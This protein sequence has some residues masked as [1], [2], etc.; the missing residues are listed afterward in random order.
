MKKR[1]AFT[2]VVAAAVL[3][4]L[5]AVAVR[6][7]AHLWAAVHPLTVVYSDAVF[8]PPESGQ[9]QSLSYRTFVVRSDG[10]A[11]RF[12]AAGSA[13]ELL[14][15]TRSLVF[16][17][18]YVVVDPHTESVTTYKP[19]HAVLRPTQDCGGSR[20]D[21]ILGRR[22]ELVTEDKSQKGRMNIT[23]RKWLALDLNC[24]PLR[25]EY[26]VEDLTVGARYKNVRSAISVAE[27]EPPVALF[28]IPPVYTERAPSDVQREID[29]KLG[30]GAH[31]SRDPAALQ[32][33]DRAYE[34]Q[35]F[36][37]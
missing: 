7:N 12:N 1:I 14:R 30:K 21:E 6:Y 17:D 19:V 2:M 23:L 27:G 33:L 15:H 18:R 20:A 9:P 34:H 31:V 13:E 22:T 5:G 29:N 32:S 3:S 4:G 37:H 35:K 28:L 8:E 26:L 25:E 24:V 11:V 10:A 16:P 36:G